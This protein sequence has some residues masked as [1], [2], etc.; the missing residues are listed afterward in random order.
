VRKEVFKVDP[1]AFITVEEV[2][3]LHRGFWRA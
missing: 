2:R 3:P 1:E